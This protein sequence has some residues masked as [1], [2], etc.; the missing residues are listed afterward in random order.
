MMDRRDQAV[1]W[2]WEKLALSDCG[3]GLTSRRTGVIREHFCR[4]FLA[5]SG[6]ETCNLLTLARLVTALHHDLLDMCS[7]L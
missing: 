5:V 4:G 3:K 6:L 1:G 2:R 7:V